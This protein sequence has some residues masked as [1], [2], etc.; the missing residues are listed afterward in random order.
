MA[1]VGRLQRGK[2][3]GGVRCMGICMLL[4]CRGF[5]AHCLLDYLSY[6]NF[7]PI[8]RNPALRD[9]LIFYFIFYF[10]NGM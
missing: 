4:P 10:S 1:R 2:Y 3:S 9:S 6:R 8:A 5:K 7:W